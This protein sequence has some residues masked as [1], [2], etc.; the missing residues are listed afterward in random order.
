MRD[1]RVLVVGCGNSA[2]DIVSDAVH[3]GSRVLHEP[4]GAAIGSCR[5][6][7]WA[8]RRMMWSRGSSA[9]PCRVSLKRWLFQASLWVLQGPPSR[10][11]LPDPD[12]SI[13]QAHPTMSDEIP[14]LSAHGR[15][16]IK[17]EIAGYDGKRVLFTDG[18]A[19]TVDMIVFA[20]GY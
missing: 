17:P 2:T 20:T 14:R 4:S 3:G 16:T 6:S 9:P 19:E 7:C 18:T 8:S 1:K 15:I 11:Q 13:D 10:Y 5:S 12:Y